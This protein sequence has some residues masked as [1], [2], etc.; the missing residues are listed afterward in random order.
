VTF[1]GLSNPGRPLNGQ[2]PTA[3]IDWGTAAWWLAGP[4]GRFSGNSVS[5]N[6]PVPTT[7]A[8]SF[9]SPRRLVQIDAYNGGVTPSTI[10]INCPGQLTKQV[11]LAPNQLSTIA[12]GWTG[13]CTG[14]TISS[15]NGWNANFNNLVIDVPLPLSVRR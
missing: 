5:F 13:V 9:V 11:T 6:G 3:V 2:Y 4:A 1:D 12:T 15:T 7:A 8:F 10:S 14:V